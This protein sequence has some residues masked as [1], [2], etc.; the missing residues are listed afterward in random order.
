MLS[1]ERTLTVALLLTAATVQA[2]DRHAALQECYAEARKNNEP[3]KI[4]GHLS[5]E[6]YALYRETL[7]RASET[8]MRAM[9]ECSR[10]FSG[11]PKLES[12]GNNPEIRP[13]QLPPR[14]NDP[15]DPTNALSDEQRDRLSR[16]LPDLQQRIDIHNRNSVCYG[17]WTTPGIAYRKAMKRQYGCPEE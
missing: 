6:E 10:R 13:M 7:Q 3:P 17:I 1:V 5:R 8:R 9:H 16:A 11:N 12:L 14:P 2:Q 4:S 15:R